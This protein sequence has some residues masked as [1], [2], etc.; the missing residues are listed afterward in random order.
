MNRPILQAVIIALVLLSGG[1]ASVFAQQSGVTEVVGGR[2]GSVFSDSEP[3]TGA[4][5]LEV[6]I[7][8]GDRLDSVQMVLELR[9]G[10]SAANPRRG[11][12]GGNSVTFRL[13][14]DEYIVGLSGRY[15]DRVDSI[16]IHTNKRT[17]ALY[18]GRGGDR[19]YRVDVPSGN[20]AVG[21][22]GR[23]GDNVD[24]IGLIYAPLQQ[25]L[26]NQ[27]AFAGGR[28]G[29]EF[30][31]DTIASGARISEVRVYAGDRI[32]AIQVV[33]SL[34]DGRVVEGAR[35]GGGGGRVQKF[36]LDSDEYIIG[37]SGR[38]GDQ[39]D[40]LRIHTNKRTSQ[41]FGGSGGSRDF[42]IDVPSGSQAVGFVGRSGRYL[43][44]IGLAHG[45]VTTP[46]RQR[47]WLR[48]I[49]G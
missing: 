47:G 49:R 22:T 45:S 7:R 21:F 31:A 32:D 3:Q 2:G 48:R 40:S 30:S 38:C 29:S 8:S 20:Q 44:A 28:G 15:G 14:S 43:D 5:V 11:G 1:E 19:D 41:V 34:S 42:K 13:E 25:S 17:S 24:A 39:I 18:G 4:R 26:S 46:S 10:S 27:T 36:A 35:R 12:S 9:D 6:R 33:Y 37:L 16:R 23:A